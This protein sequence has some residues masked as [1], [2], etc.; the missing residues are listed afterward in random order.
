[1]LKQRAARK[2]VNGPGEKGY[3]DAR[4]TVL[5]FS[6]LLSMCFSCNVKNAKMHVPYSKKKRIKAVGHN[7]T[8]T[9]HKICTALK[10]INIVNLNFWSSHPIISFPAIIISFIIHL[11]PAE[12]TNACKN[13]NNNACY[14]PLWL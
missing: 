12:A 7:T 5:Y 9:S 11:K 14:I 8:L 3:C 2:I 6:H 13:Y 10:Y 4:P 1:M